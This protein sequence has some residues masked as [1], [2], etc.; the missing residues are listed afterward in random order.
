MPNHGKRI[1]RKFF[2]SRVFWTTGGNSGNTRVLR[3]YKSSET[4]D[5]WAFEPKKALAKSAILGKK[6]KKRGDF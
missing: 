2:I 4:P 3:A 1:F 6:K 5:I